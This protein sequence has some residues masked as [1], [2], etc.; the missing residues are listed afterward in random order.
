MGDDLIHK[1]HVLTALLQLCLLALLPLEV[2][3]LLWLSRSQ[4]GTR[5]R[6]ARSN[7]GVVTARA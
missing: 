7:D 6:K 1:L 5:V 3:R 2:L 4:V